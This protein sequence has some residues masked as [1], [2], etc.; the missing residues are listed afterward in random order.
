MPTKGSLESRGA[1]ALTKSTGIPIEAALKECKMVALV[2]MEPWN[3]NVSRIVPG[4]FDKNLF[5]I[6]PS[7]FLALVCG[8]FD[9]FKK[10]ITWSGGM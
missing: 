2:V 4:T 7:T 3:V 5:R 6:N 9:F 8:H 1:P 10:T